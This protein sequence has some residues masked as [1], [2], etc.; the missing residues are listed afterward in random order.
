VGRE[1]GKIAQTLRSPATGAELP[2]YK[3]PVIGRFVGETAG[4]ASVASKFYANLEK[5]GEH[6][7]PVK[8]MGL[9]HESA[10]MQEYL[11]DHPE[12]R[13]V[14]AAGTMQEKIAELRR[15]KERLVR[16]GAD[17]SR[18]RA[19]E[20]RAKLAMQNFNATVARVEKQKP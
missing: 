11:R 1:I 8:R 20:E 13:L 6:A 16:E 18:V 19:I 9:A 17:K 10:R 14:Q 4:A 3:V 15:E 5:I 12:A 7:D 2:L